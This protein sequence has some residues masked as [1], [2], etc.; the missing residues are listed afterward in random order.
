MG[1]SQDSTYTIEMYASTTANANRRAKFTAVGATTVMVDPF[2]IGNNSTELWTVS[3]MLPD[4]ANK[5]SLSM[6]MGTGSTGNNVCFNCMRITS[7]IKVGVGPAISTTGTLSAV[8]TTYGTASSSPTTFSVSGANMSAGILVTPPAGYEVSLA[9]GSGYAATVTV[10]A[11]GTISSTPVYVRLLAT[12]NVASSP[13]SGNIT[14]TSSGATQVNVA[15]VSSTVSAKGLTITGLTGANKPYDGGTTASFTGTAAYSGLENGDSPA[16]AGT[17]SAIFANANAADGKTITVSGYT[18]PTT[19]YTVTQ[20]TLTGNI[21]KVALT[22]TAANQ[23][24]AY[25]T[26]V[27][28]VTGAGT[29]TPTGFVNSETSTVISGS[30]T[31]NTN[32]TNSTAAATSG[33]TI[34][35]VVNGLS[36]TNYSF[37]PANGSITITPADVSVSNP[38]ISVSSLVLSPVSNIIQLSQALF[39]PLAVGF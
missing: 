36:A 14:L 16:I 39:N 35:P 30:V 12:A 10:G 9:S 18:A 37:T 13:Y 5:I 23:T 11:A 17:P 6:V 24:V 1:L 15:T 38:N 8:S 28:T 7:A 2:L 33:I 4:G 25:G 22:I 21:S 32:Y 20:P 3:T 31:Y 26:D 27:A 34:T 19:N 29:Y